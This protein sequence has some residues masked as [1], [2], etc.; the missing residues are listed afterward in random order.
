MTETTAAPT[1]RPA[2]SKRRLYS[3][4]GTVITLGALSIGATWLLPDSNHSIPSPWAVLLTI[5]LTALS[6]TA[7]MHLRY[8]RENYTLTWSEAAIVVG[9]VLTPWPW[10]ALACPVG[11][12]IAQI[13]ARRDPIKI[14][15]NA[16][17]VALEAVLA[18]VC[19]S[20]FPRGLYYPLPLYCYAPASI[21]AI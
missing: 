9:L 13:I 21:R 15:F 14:A 18:S 16:A 2:P 19:V 3:V 5:G 4:I 7:V 1:P 20:S 11:V 17:T 10:V 12:M 8:G 6:D